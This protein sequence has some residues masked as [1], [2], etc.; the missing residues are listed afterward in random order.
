MDRLISPDELEAIRDLIIKSRDP[1]KPCLA[2]C[3][4][5]GCLALGGAKVITAFKRELQD[6]GLDTKVDLR[7]TGCPGFVR[8]VRWLLLSLKAYST[9]R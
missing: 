6:Q 9:S 1:N 2:I 8:E 7:I 5:T 3:G 4:G